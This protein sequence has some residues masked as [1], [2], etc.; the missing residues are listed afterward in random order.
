MRDSAESRAASQ[1]DRLLPALAGGYADVDDR[2]FSELLDFGVEVSRLVNFVSSTGEVDGDWSE[3]FQ[4]DP[5]MLLAALGGIDTTGIESQ[6]LSIVRAAIR[7]PDVEEKFSL[8]RRLFQFLFESAQRFDQLRAAAHRFAPIR[9]E[10]GWQIKNGAA[11]EAVR[12]LK[13]YADGSE[14]GLGTDHAIRLDFRRFDAAWRLDS[15]AADAS[16]YVG[17]GVREKIDRAMGVII[18]SVFHRLMEA[19]A[20][21]K[22]WARTGLEEGLQQPDHPPQMALYIAFVKLFGHAQTRMNRF[23]VRFA[24]FYHQRVLRDSPLPAS[25]D[26]VYLNFS[27]SGTPVTIPRGT[28]FG[29][30]ES[31]DRRQ[32]VFESDSELSVTSASIA[33]IRTLRNN[34]RRIFCSEVSPGEPWAIFGSEGGR[35]AK[36]GFAVAS[37]CLLLGGG[38][39]SVDL[40][41]NFSAPL[42][43]DIR[44]DPDGFSV[45][46]ST[47][48][49]WFEIEG[50][51]I[52]TGGS[53]LDFRLTLPASAPSLV[54]SCDGGEHPA[55]DLPTLKF[56]FDQE[57]IP[58]SLLE[59]EI[60]SI[61]IAVEV[62][63][64]PARH[65][66]NTDGTIDPAL[67]FPLFGS[68]PSVGSALL[69][70]EP[71]LH[72]KRLTGLRVTLDWGRLPQTESGL[73]GYYGGYVIGLDGEP[74]PE[75]IKNDSF[76][77]A[78]S[79]DQ[80]AAWDLLREQD[81]ALFQGAADG[82]LQDETSFGDFDLAE[83]RSWAAESA[84][85]IELCSPP[86]AFGNEIYAANL[87]RATSEIGSAETRLPNGPYLPQVE[88]VRLGYRASCVLGGSP[89]ERSQFFHLLPFGDYVEPASAEDRTS[90]LP[91]IPQ[92]GSLFIGFDG[93]RPPVTQSLLFQMVPGGDG[94]GL[95]WDWVSAEQELVPV[96]VLEDSTGGLQES[97]IVSLKIPAAAGSDR[98][99]QWLR[100]STRTP[101]SFPACVQIVPN[102]VAA[103]RQA[104][105]SCDERPL[106]PETIV[107]ALDDLPGIDQ[108][109]QPLPSFGGRCAETDPLFAARVGERLRHKDR[110]SSDGIWS[111]WSSGNSRRST[112]SG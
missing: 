52:Q 102:A 75:P 14:G 35:E 54:A 96:G 86:F 15:A 47:R 78:I 107:R 63:D 97:G 7:A 24:E 112:K 61:G 6:F 48:S 71:E 70:R 105:Q 10:L 27:S 36:L 81:R 40:T 72:S 82:K 23:A 85:R 92:G 11:G 55:P 13:A 50:V 51:E 53:A 1:R 16:I 22:R 69:V 64:L 8:L 20:A 66:E 94:G 91:E 43:R 12:K 2:S 25:P 33:S 103:T 37:T 77:V 65:L 32:F 42:G 41:V 29:G 73:E 76:R 100:I 79:V 49:G 67:P 80:P 87:A 28:R 106:P 110:G 101:E 3:F 111:V 99:L 45:F 89:C 19:F 84:L 57:P 74:L 98:E 93:L 21:L 62:Q 68:T 59:L 5:T 39:R 46:G 30:A 104:E 9:R 18:G 95:D 38:D 109:R 26:K 83:N 58:P 4:S 44:I 60:S 108:I 31:D 90:L 56:Y 17:S 34:G 88:G